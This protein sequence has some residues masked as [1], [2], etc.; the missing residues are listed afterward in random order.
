MKRFRIAFTALVFLGIAV[1]FLAE[2]LEKPEPPDSGFGAFHPVALAPLEAP[3]GTLTLAGRVETEAGTP[4]GDVQVTLFPE[5][6]H[7][8][9]AEP[10]HWTF[11]DDAGRFALTHLAPG[12]YQVVLVGPPAPPTKLALAL[13]CEG[14]VTWRLSAPLP[15]LPVLPE[16]ERRRIEGQVA[17][18]RASPAE[19]P[20]AAAGYEVVLRPAPE[21]PALSG[22]VVR[23]ALSDATGRFVLDELVL[24]RYRVE[25]L[26]PWARGGSWPVLA[27]GELEVSRTSPGGEL[28]FELQVGELAGELIEARGLPLEGALI[29]VFA[30]EA[31]DPSGAHLA[32]PPTVTDAWG[33]FLVGDLPP[34]RYGLH[35]R[36]GGA[37]RDVEARVSAGQRTVVPLERMDPRGR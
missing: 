14:E 6:P 23:R 17:R 13:P 24:A 30:L 1:G 21:V 32:W 33:R 15:P 9:E 20:S 37:R 5:D 26:P 25:I 2:R 4:A 31:Q 34:G 19:E 10:L 35:L 8:P 36:A 28:T 18:P 29:E 16:I 11:T 22:A 12:D 3:G 7:A 27:A